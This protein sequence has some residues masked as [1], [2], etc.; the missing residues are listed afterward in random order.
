MMC[1]SCTK[2]KCVFKEYAGS[3]APEKLAQ[4]HLGLHFPCMFEGTFLWA[5]AHH[6]KYNIN[7]LHMK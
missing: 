2:L 6:R 1:S 7:T 3:K 5:M 4:E